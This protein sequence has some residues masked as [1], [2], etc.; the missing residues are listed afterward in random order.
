M[1][2]RTVWVG[3]VFPKKEL[4]LLLCETQKKDGGLLRI[5]DATPLGECSGILEVYATQGLP[6]GM[7]RNPLHGAMKGGQG[8]DGDLKAR[9][10]RKIGTKARTRY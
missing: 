9:H 5:W 6:L 2:E 7:H 10:A 1:E 3:G 4:C 8:S